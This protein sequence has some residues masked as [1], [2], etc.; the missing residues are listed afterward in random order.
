MNSKKAVAGI[1]Q[2]LLLS[3]RRPSDLK[4]NTGPPRGPE[5]GKPKVIGTSSTTL[6]GD[7]HHRP[8]I[9][10]SYVIGLRKVALDLIGRGAE[11]QLLHRLAIVRPGDLLLIVVAHGSEDRAKS[12]RLHGDEPVRL[13]RASEAAC[14][15]RG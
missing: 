2:R 6:S 8:D 11:L 7:P 9:V 1:R 15:S 13:A 5:G 12:A 10:D 4:L 3:N 14:V